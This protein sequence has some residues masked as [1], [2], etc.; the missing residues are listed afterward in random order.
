M[1]DFN[2]ISVEITKDFA[3]VITVSKMGL[4]IPIGVGLEGKLGWGELSICK[5]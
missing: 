5:N 2:K 1:F 3:L 4:T